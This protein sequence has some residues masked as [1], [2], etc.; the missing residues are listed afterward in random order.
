MLLEMLSA[1]TCRGWW[2]VQAAVEDK[3]VTRTDT[4]IDNVIFLAFAIKRP[5]AIA[6]KAEIEA[7]DDGPRTQGRICIAI[8]Q[9]KRGS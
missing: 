6:L 7:D 5:G 4:R 8:G 9:C 3:T 2:E 1:T